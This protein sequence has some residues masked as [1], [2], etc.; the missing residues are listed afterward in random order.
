VLATSVPSATLEARLLEERWL[1][2]FHAG[3]TATIAAVYREHF[4]LVRSA[5]AAVLSGADRETVIHE[6]FF[7]L[8]SVEKL[9]R[10]YQGG[11]FSSWL[12]AVAKHQAIDYARRRA[13]ETPDGLV[14]TSDGSVV[15]IERQLEARVLIQQFQRE[16]L[17]AEWHGVFEARFIRQL[18]QREA[19]HSLGIPRTTLLYRE[20][21]IRKLLR[22][23][24]L[25]PEKRS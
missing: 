16:V 8:L 5:V 25:H 6:V 2:G 22:A 24:L 4:D 21:R 1:A 10:G 7:R 18:D 11:S 19:A 9:R 20:H 23:F 12:F 14:P 3:H 17:P 13:R 15:H